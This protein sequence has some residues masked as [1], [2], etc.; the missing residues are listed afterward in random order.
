MK[1]LKT[2]A[3]K[4]KNVILFIISFLGCH[5]VTTLASESN[6][7]KVLGHFDTASIS[8]NRLSLHGWIVNLDNSVEINA[9]VVKADSNVVYEGVFEREPRPD[10]IKALQIKNLENPG[11]MV[12]FELQSP[13]IAEI[14]VEFKLSDGKIVQLPNYLFPSFKA[15]NNKNISEKYYLCSLL[16]LTLCLS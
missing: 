8:G 15:E 11:W 10:V 13:T 4:N 16:F 7:S 1:F 6:D 9:I 12:D 2:S 5:V 3:N 14:K